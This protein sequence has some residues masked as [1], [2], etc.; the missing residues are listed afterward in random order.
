MQEE[1]KLKNAEK[2]AEDS[3]KL[4]PSR[5]KRGGF[6]GL[7]IELAGIVIGAF[8][9]AFVIRTFIAQPFFVKG[10]SMEPNYLEREYLIIDEISYRFRDPKRGEVIVFKYPKDLR[11]YYIK[12]IIG[13][14]NETVSIKNGKIIIYNEEYKD[15]VE[16]DE[17]YL[18]NN[19]FTA[20]DV[21][22][23]L[24]EDD[25]YVLG[26]NRPR[27]SDS[28]QWGALDGRYI[29]GKTWARIWPLNQLSI[30]NE[31]F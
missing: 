1:L 10:Q 3:K 25:Y 17:P 18:M 27:S 11:T 7:T 26:D 15:G 21:Y 5:K 13:L 16:L 8:L 24:G 31:Q 14:P 23:V 22:E 20:G 29:I 19:V 9:F 30:I 4:R 2:E 12:R 28:R 6:L